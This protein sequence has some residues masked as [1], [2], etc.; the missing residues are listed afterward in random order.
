[1]DSA[2]IDRGSACPS[3]SVNG[4]GFFR[5]ILDAVDQPLLVVDAETYRVDWTNAAGRCMVCG[6]EPFC[7]ALVQHLEG[8]CAEQGDQCPLEQVKRTG[9]PATAE[10]LCLD[11]KGNPHRA[12]IR[13]YPI[14]NDRGQV[15]QVALTVTDPSPALEAEAALKKSQRLLDDVGAVAK[16][17]GWEMDLVTRQATWTRGT[18]DI[19]GIAPGQPV[20]GPDEHINYY[21][22]EF[23][24][25]VA[26]AMRAL[27]EEDKPLEF[28]ACFRTPSGE[29]KWCRAL[30]Q[31]ERRDGRCVRVY[32]TFQD[33]TEHRR[34][35]EELENHKERLEE[36]VRKRTQEL[37]ERLKELNC[38]YR[39]TDIAE[40]PGISVERLI[41]LTLD[42]VPAAFHD[43]A[44]TCARICMEER[45]YRTQ[46]FQETPRKLTSDIVVFGLPVGRL[47][48]FSLKENLGPDVVPFYGEENALLG[49]VTERLGRIIERKKTETVMDL[50]KFPSEN[51]NPVLRITKDG[52]VLYSNDAGKALLAHWHCNVGQVVPE[53]WRA[54]VAQIFE[55]GQGR[56]EEAEVGDRILSM[57]LSP[58]VEAGYVNLYGS[59]I[60]ARRQSERKLQQSEERFKLMMRQ[61]PSVI[62]L[63]DLDGLQVDVNEAYEELWGFPAGHTVGKFNF[64]ASEEV[65]RK[66]LL[67]YAQEAYS[68]RTVSVPE[69]E[70]DSRGA[71][72]AQ[73][74][75]R[76]RWL[77][78][79]IYPLKDPSGTVQNI[80]VTHED[81]TERR[82]A[83]EERELTITLLSLLNTN[84][85]MHELMKQVVMFLKRRSQCEAVG[86]RLRDGDDFPYYESQGFPEE[87]ILAESRLCSVDETGQPV[88]DAGGKVY[89]ECM[90]GNVLSGRFDPSKPFFTEHG[91]FWTNSTTELLTSTAD[92]DREART[93]NRCNTAGYESVAL[94]PL[95]VAGETFGL[96]QFNDKN[97]GC[98]TPEKIAL[99]ERLADNLAIGLAQR[100]AE[101]TA[102]R[103]REELIAQQRA[104]KESVRA[105]L[106]RVKAELVRKT[107]LAAIGQVSGSI[108]HDLRNPLASVR[109]ANYLLKRRLPKDDPRLVDL[110][111]I[112]DHEVSRA[113]QIITNLLSLAQRRTCEKRAIDLGRL[114]QD[115]L[116]RVARPD[117][118][119]CTCALGPIPFMILA[120]P[121]QFGQ[122]ISNILDNAVA[123]MGHEGRFLVEAAHGPDMDVIEF[124]DTG[125]GIPAEV[126]DKLLEP[127]VTTKARGTGLGLTICRQIVES[128]KGQIEARNRP[129]GGALIQIHLPPI[130]KQ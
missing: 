27:I 89:L 59:D 117:G 35:V 76:V 65:K 102:L 119:T 122:V 14:F 57:A 29:L 80:V 48:V 33:I 6:G 61:S 26:E 25:M 47:E 108:A 115:V 72:E 53:E 99:Y 45:E 20:P 121:D 39:M 116:D 77:S 23:R 130:E 43:P 82:W 70:Y 10:H 22:P 90:C 1:M 58:I 118:I 7:Y 93:R 125:A 44:T 112:I 120:D 123:A 74:R 32:G 51:P 28:E 109:N 19:V 97:E 37:G 94:V 83:E 88:R 104:E 12:E 63:Y 71:T 16:V 96:L 127:L 81:V 66:G 30:G 124:K 68:G 55:A 49:A 111:K 92:A 84:N 101:A 9:Q 8:P 56:T 129:E 54:I 42:L 95:R 86:I 24:S 31:A 17:G 78:T 41:Q 52:R 73:G 69:Y 106:D 3:G 113:D 2:R 107:Q 87:F 75:G 46:G 11:G 126:Q 13:A 18:Y 128:H 4:G 15:A 38:L 60:T 110:L 64:L 5:R 100:R 62:E 34:V 85:D 50:A 114:V 105:E 21:L 40:E 98:F 67:P 36:L 103:A 91:S 79:H